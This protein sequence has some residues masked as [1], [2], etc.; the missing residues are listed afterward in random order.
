MYLTKTAVI[1][2]TIGKISNS[3]G[4]AINHEIA[5]EL[6]QRLINW[7]VKP[8]TLIVLMNETSI[9]IKTE[10]KNGITI[11]LYLAGSFGIPKTMVGGV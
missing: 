10:R 1:F 5:Q 3:V 9:D 7:Y 8:E 6:I 4:K 2:L 11:P